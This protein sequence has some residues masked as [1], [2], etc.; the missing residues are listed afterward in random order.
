[1]VKRVGV[2][3]GRS[4]DG[5]YGFWV[6]DLG[7]RANVATRNLHERLSAAAGT[8][9]ED[10]YQI[11][12]SQEA[13]TEMIVQ[14]SGAGGPILSEKDKDGM[15]SQGQMELIAE[16]GGDWRRKYFHDVTVHSQ[17]VLANVRDGGLKRDLTA[18]FA[19]DGRVPESSAGKDD[20]L[21]D[22]DRLVGPANPVAAARDGI[23]W[24]DTRHKTAVP[25]FG[26]LRKWAGLSLQ[27][28]LLDDQLAAVPPKTL[29]EPEPAVVDELAMSN[30]KPVDLGLMDEPSLVPVLVEGSMYS[31]VSWHRNPSGS[32][33]PYNVRLHTYPRVVLWNPYN[34]KL[35]LD[36]S[37]VLLHM[38]GRKEMWTDGI[39]QLGD[40][41]FSVR[42][43]WI[44]FVGG[45]NN[46]FRSEDGILQSL[47]YNDPYIGS[48]YFSLPKTTF[49]PGECLVFSPDQ[50]NEYDTTNTERNTLS[51]AY[52]PDPALNYYFT[53]SELDGGM[54]FRPTEYWFAPTEYWNVKNQSDDF[55]MMLKQRGTQTGIAPEVFDKLPQIAYVSC[56]L[57][58]GAGREPRVAWNESNKVPMEETELRNPVARQIPDVRTRDGYRLRWFREHESN[59]LASGQLQRGRDAP[60]FESALLANWNPRGT[61]A[62]RTP[63]DNLA[64]Q[65]ARDGSGSGPWFF[66]A[67]TRDLYDE[68]TLG[69]NNNLPPQRG[70]TYRGNPFGPV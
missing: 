46:Q 26:L 12:A 3:S 70:G 41:Q 54:D 4:G 30:L 31:S 17:G 61:Y 20:G 27:V 16:T 28:G 25:R 56:A 53:A 65:V 67:Y 23:A 47:G 8:S 14:G 48:Y 24:G 68:E 18:F 19:S 64:G 60:H 6:G 15:I 5:H 1:M 38:N 42:A 34:V 39:L 29:P 51:P 45:R 59:I 32:R 36:P 63:W 7:V 35:T 11:M 21:S 33:Y 44:W 2:D 13:R 37:M 40:R 50:A 57:Q 52:A 43:Q 55:R 58:Y 69:W 62:A 22:S 49:G 10:L 9:R 66:G